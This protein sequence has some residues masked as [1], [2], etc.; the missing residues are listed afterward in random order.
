MILHRRTQALAAV[1]G[2]EHQVVDGGVE[3]LDDALDHVIA[4]PVHDQVVP[5]CV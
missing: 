2:L 5:L 1:E 3:P 4:G